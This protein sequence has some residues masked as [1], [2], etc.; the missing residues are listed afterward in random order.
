MP[1]MTNAAPSTM[2]VP[3]ENRPAKIALIA[4]LLSFIPGVGIVAMIAGV[5]G[6][7]QVHTTGTGRGRSFVGVVLGMGSLLLWT[8]LV[9]AYFQGQALMR[10]APALDASKKFIMLVG[11]GNVTAAKG[12]CTDAIDVDRLTATAEQFEQLGGFTGDINA[13]GGR[14][15]GG[16][17]QVDYEL[18]FAKSNQLFV[19][20]WTVI[21]KQPRLVD[22]SMSVI[23][24]PAT[25]PA[26]PQK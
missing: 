13:S 18:P 22:Y 15:K 20:E 12:M 16:N 1:A 19:T 3:R 10:A 6:G 25:Q 9:G 24:D 11:S 8:M 4:G 23:P 2:P 21:D 7:A 26:R 5:V 14:P 17:V